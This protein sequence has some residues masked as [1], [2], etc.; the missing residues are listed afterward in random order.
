[1]LQG[2][3]L[4]ACA[5]GDAPPVWATSPAPRTARTMPPEITL[6]KVSEE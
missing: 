5:A 4:A 3:K 6:R 2:V 1:M